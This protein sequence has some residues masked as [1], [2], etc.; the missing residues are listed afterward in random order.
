MLNFIFFKANMIVIFLT[1]LSFGIANAQDVNIKIDFHPPGESKTTNPVTITLNGKIYSNGW[2][3]DEVQAGKYKANDEE[4]FLIRVL[5][6]NTNGKIDEIAKLFLPD[7]AKDIKDKFTEYPDMFAR[8]KNYFK[9]IAK[10]TFLAKINYGDYT[11]FI[12]QHSGVLIG[13]RKKIYPI[14]KLDETYYLTNKLADDPFYLYIAYKYKEQLQL[15][16][17]E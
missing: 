17:R 11:I 13:D 6:V 1:I 8:N 4:L 14:K 15:K 3:F 9:N 2:W 12:V 5:D 7:E 10:S 16:N